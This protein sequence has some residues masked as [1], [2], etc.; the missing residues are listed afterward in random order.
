MKT[1]LTMSALLFLISGNAFAGSQYDACIKKVKS[2]KAKEASN[3][4]GLKYLLDPSSCFR[5]QKEL[6]EIDSTCAAIGAA[7]KVDVSAPKTVPENKVTAAPQKPAEAAPAAAVPDKSAA[8]VVPAPPHKPAAQTPP[9]QPVVSVEPTVETACDQARTE[10]AR[11]KS[12]NIRLRAE[13][14]KLR[15]AVPH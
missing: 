4:S 6:K 13:N 2:L 7:E 14:E 11:L 5:T 1:I 9:A 10:N 8:G 3:C 12:E 15:K